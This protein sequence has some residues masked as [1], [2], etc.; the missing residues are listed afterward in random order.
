MSLFKVG[1]RV[2][3]IDD[4][5]VFRKHKIY[6]ITR[7]YNLDNREETFVNIKGVCGGYFDSR[8]KHFKPKPI[9]KQD[10]L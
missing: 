1:D 7:V 6:T 4:Y 10:W 2:I 9:N 8:F 3:P 5:G